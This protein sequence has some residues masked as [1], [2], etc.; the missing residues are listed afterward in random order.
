MNRS[1]DNPFDIIDRRAMVSLGPL[2][3]NK[4]CSYS[5]LFCYVPNGFLQYASL[6]IHDI[7]NYLKKHESEFD[8]IYISG[9]TDSFA[10]PRLQEGLELL[11]R[12]A[13]EFS[14]DILITTRICMNINIT[15]KLKHAAK[16]LSEKDKNLFV[17]I[18]ISSPYTDRRIEPLPIPSIKSR[19]DTLNRLKEN[20]LFSILALR[21]F[22]PIYNT[23]DY[24]IMIDSLKNSVDI[25]LGEVWYHDINHEM[26]QNLTGNNTINKGVS[27]KDALSFSASKRIW[28]VWRDTQMEKDIAEHCKTL[29]IPFFME[30]APAIEHLKS[31]RCKK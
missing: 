24:I 10:P 4:H 13:N 16:I 7:C 14:K 18:S 11:S 9:D 23:K 30:S 3:S 1:M 27:R 26:W 21:P 6:E 25:I 31:L 19:I 8:I 5:C 17:C 15:R 22:L 29:K 2:T 28:E 20:G 12:L